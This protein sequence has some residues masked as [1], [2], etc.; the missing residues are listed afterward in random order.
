MRGLSGW[1]GKFS[2]GLVSAPEAAS[3][4]YLQIHSA[5]N[6]EAVQ[7]TEGSASLLLPP[8]RPPGCVCKSL[9]PL[10]VCFCQTEAFIH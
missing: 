2:W 6:A 1:M 7:E 10:S 8:P 3:A 5:Q 9:S 4:F